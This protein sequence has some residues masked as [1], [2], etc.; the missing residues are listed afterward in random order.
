MYSS[1]QLLNE[2]CRRENEA[3]IGWVRSRFMIIVISQNCV[4]YVEP[5]SLRM[6]N[7]L[8]ICFTV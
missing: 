7:K 8:C 4:R 6:M 3:S 1:F 5:E 2:V